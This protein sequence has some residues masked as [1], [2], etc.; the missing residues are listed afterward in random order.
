MMETHVHLRR[1]GSVDIYATSPTRI[2]RHDEA[3]GP[4]DRAFETNF[5]TPEHRKVRVTS[6]SAP[7]DSGRFGLGDLSGKAG[8]RGVSSVTTSSKA[9][10]SA[11]RAL[12]V[13]GRGGG[14][15]AT[16]E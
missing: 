9:V 5:E 1:S 15:L 13:G 3:P 4:E 10:L 7:R 8:G 14:A 6:E 2:H 16:R 12:Q 11:L